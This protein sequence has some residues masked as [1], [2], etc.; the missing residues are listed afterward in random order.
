MQVPYS[1]LSNDEIRLYYTGDPFEFVL[2]KPVRTEPGVAWYYNGG[3]TMLLAGIIQKLTGKTFLSYAEEVLFDPLGISD[4]EW[5]GVSFWQ[6]GLPAAA[7]GLRLRGRD[8]AKIGSLMIRDGK[9]NGIQ[10]VPAQW[11]RVSSMRHMEQTN[12]KWSMGGIYGYGY[13]WWHGKFP[14]RW[15]NATVIT[16]VGYGGQSLFV[17]PEKGLVVTVFAGNYG[18]GNWTMPEEI[19]AEVLAAAP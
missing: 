1:S 17:V 15:E 14:A 16:G 12:S 3:T 13:Q 5:R 18:K 9:W 8:L 7:S 6:R 2:S 4:Y 19:L 10:V 11:V